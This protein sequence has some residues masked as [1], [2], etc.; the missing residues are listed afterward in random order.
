MTIDLT[1]TTTE[2]IDRALT[3]ARRRLGGMTVGMV[4][5]LILVTDEEGQYDAIRA[6][7]QAAREHPMRVLAVI[8]RKPKA[9]SRLD[10]EIRVGESS[11]G[12]T[13]VLRMYGPLGQHADSVVAPLLVPDVPVVTWWPENAPAVPAAHPLGA[14]AQRRV[15]DSAAAEDPE[16]VLAALAR[17]Y[18]PGDTDFGWTRATPWRSLLA[19]TLDQEHP[20]LET[21][22]VQAEQDNPTADLITAWLGLRLE[23]PVRRTVSAGPGITGVAFATSAGDIRVSRTDGRTATLSW[24]GR[25]D[26]MVALHRRET[27]ELLAEELR[28]LDP[29]DVYAETLARLK[30]AGADLVEAGP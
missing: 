19:A 16:Q 20:T 12:E 22:E 28:R 14:L 30:P 29:D 27:A 10:A 15:T 3:E 13:V 18:R 21:G 11:P 25:P 8:T 2:A 5:T 26:R 4:L 24:P 17:A 6:A 7:N 9:D 23:I 1:D